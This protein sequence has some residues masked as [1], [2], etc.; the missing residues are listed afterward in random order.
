MKQLE[1]KKGSESNNVKS[2]YQTGTGRKK[3]A[4]RKVNEGK[5]L[6]VHFLYKQDGKRNLT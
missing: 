1:N 3:W 6:N 4:G 5:G 2:D